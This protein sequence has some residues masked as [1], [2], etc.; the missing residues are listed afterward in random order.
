MACPD[1][2]V[3]PE[4]WRERRAIDGSGNIDDARTEYLHIILQTPAP[5]IEDI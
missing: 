3:M 1:E 5:P 4:G 2:A